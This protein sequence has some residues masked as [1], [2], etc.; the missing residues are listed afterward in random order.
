MELV[1]G[2]LS[3]ILGGGFVIGFLIGIT[4][5]GA[6]SLTT[7]L[8]ISGVGVSPAVAVGTD[9]L[10]AAITKMS[11]AWRHQRLDNVD[12]PILGW[13]AAGSLPG[14]ASILLWLYLAEPETTLV[15]LY[16]KKA[17]AMTLIVSAAVILL[18]PFLRRFQPQSFDEP[19]TRM[20]ARPLPTVLFGLILGAAVALT[21]V[22]A[23]AIGVAVLTG[24]Y[25]YMM[26]RRVVGTDI[27]HAVPL[28]FVAGAGHAG[29]GHVDALLLASLL[30]GSI[31]GILIGSRLTGKLPDWILRVGLSAILFFAA[32]VLLLR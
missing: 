15:T 10:F 31:P 7:P 19:P 18:H 5:V 23:G 24:L 3:L 14:A 2:S 11:A 29:M 17:L 25:P 26:A 30:C 16:V 21:S 32:Y 9:L 13:L 12:W 22:G 20:A 27:V 8:L 28:T 1:L 6:G 4:G